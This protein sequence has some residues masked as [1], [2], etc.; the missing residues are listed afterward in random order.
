MKKNIIKSS[1]FK[2]VDEKL[3]E[4]K[5]LHLKSGLDNKI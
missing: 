2:G 3:N 1:I 4:T 5:E